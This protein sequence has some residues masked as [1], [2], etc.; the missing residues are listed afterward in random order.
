MYKPVTIKPRQ[1]HHNHHKTGSKKLKI[2]L[3]HNTN[4]PTINE[5]TGITSILFLSPLKIEVNPNLFDWDKSTKI[6]FIDFKVI[7]KTRI[8]PRKNNAPPSPN[9]ANRIFPGSLNL[10]DQAIEL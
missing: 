6:R 1:S 4:Q 5:K 3:I 8:K 2:P 10:N 7:N 9:Q